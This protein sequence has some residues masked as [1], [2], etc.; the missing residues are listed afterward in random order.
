MSSNRVFPQ[1]L[2]RV[3]HSSTLLLNARH[4]SCICSHAG[5]WLLKAGQQG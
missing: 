3:S 4:I 2:V 1:S 5:F